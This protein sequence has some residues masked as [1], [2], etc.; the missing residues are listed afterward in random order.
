MILS[1]VS[2]GALA[3]LRKKEV[4]RSV[5]EKD[6]GISTSIYTMKGRKAGKRALYFREDEKY[7]YVPRNYVWAKNSRVGNLI[8]ERIIGDP[9]DV[10]FTKEL[11]DYQAEFIEDY[12]EVIK[13]EDDIVIE[14]GCGSGKCHT[15]GTKIWMYDGS[16]KNVEDIGVGELLMGDDGSPRKV[17]S[18]ARGKEMCYN[19]HQKNGMTY[20][21]NE[22]HILSLRYRPWGDRKKIETYNEVRDISVKEYLS[23]SKKQQGF[24]YGYKNKLSFDE[25]AV[26]IDPYFL[27]LWLADGRADKPS[28]TI[29]NY[30]YELVHYV[31]SFAQKESLFVREEYNSENSI[32]YHLN[33]GRKGGKN[34]LLDA[35]REIGVIGNKNIPDNFLYNSE[36]NRLL[37]LAGILDGDGFGDRKGF[38]IAQKKGKLSDDIR[39]LCNSLGFRVSV[40]DKEVKGVLYD[41]MYISGDTQMI[42]NKLPRKKQGIREINKDPRVTGITL[43]PIGEQEYFGFELDGNRRYCLADGT[44]TH[45]TALSLYLI[46]KRGRRTVILVPTNF[47]ADQYEKRANFFLSGAKIVRAS[48]SKKKIAWEDADLLI[49]SYELYK[50]RTFPEEFYYRFGHFV[51]DEGHRIGADSHEEI[52]TRLHTKYRTMLT[53]TFRREDGAEKILKHHFGTI[54]TM[55]KVNPDVYVH[56]VRTEIRVGELISLKKLSPKDWAIWNNTLE[57]IGDREGMYYRIVDGILEIHYHE[58]RWKRLQISYFAYTKEEKRVIDAICR[59]AEYYLKNPQYTILHSFVSKLKMR[60]LEILRVVGNLVKSG[61]KVLVLGQRKEQLYTLEE[62]LKSKGLNTLVIVSETIKVMQK[63]DTLEEL[64]S[65]ADVVLGIDKLAKEGMDVDSLD[66]LMLIHPIGDTEQ[67]LGRVARIKEGKK[68]PLC[69]YLVDETTPYKNIFKKSQKFIPRNGKL[70]NPISIHQ[71]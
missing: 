24:L 18:L 52:T 61:R 36:K 10:S 26:P 42:P 12:Q 66:T 71:L 40:S 22:S 14:A 57:K 59:K 65:S 19:V 5:L 29:A 28:I 2:Y 20:G 9:I 43:E 70:K 13:N 67:A 62:R 15:R 33:S 69:L 50:V 55:K 47:L 41:R 68:E 11:R 16:I 34:H 37:L 64:S 25:K 58:D 8:D 46:A 53:A 48:P 21:V 56:P 44:V 35:L 27:G 60:N 38:E 17:L 3:R 63:E 39:K 7:F 31:K 54:I 45:N 23:L 6:L 4:S 32:N 49:I 51:V 30:D 1:E